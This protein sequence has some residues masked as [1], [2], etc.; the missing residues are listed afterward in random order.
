[1]PEEPY[2]IP[3]GEADVVRE[4]GDVT[5]VALGRMVHLAEPGR[6]RARGRGHR[7]RDHRPAHDLAARRGHDPRERREHRPAR[8]RRRGQPALRVRGRHRS[9]W[10]PSA[11]LRGRSRR[12]RGW[13]RRRTRRCRSARSLEDAYVPDAATRSP[14]AVRATDRQRGGHA[15]MSAADR[16]ARHAQVGPVDDRGPAHRLARRRGRRARQSATRSPRSR[17]RRS[18][19]WSR[20]PAAGV[21]RRRVAAEDEVIPVGGLLGV[22]ADAAAPDEEIDA[23]VAEFQATLRARARRPRTRARPPRDGRGRGRPA[24]PRARAR[25]ASRSCS[26]TASAATSTT[27]CSTPSRWRPSAPSTRSTCPATAARSRRRRRPRG[28]GAARVPGRRQG[29]ERA[30]LVGHSMGGLVAGELRGRATPERV[31][32]LTL[33][34]PARAS[35]P[36]ID[37]EYIDGFIAASRR[38]SSSRCCSCCSPTRTSSPAD[39]RRRAQVQ[40]ARRRRRRAGGPARRAVR[41][42]PP[43]PL[44]RSLA[45]YSGPL[46]VIWGERDAIIPA[47][48]AEAAPDGAEVKS[49]R[50]GHSP[51]MEAA[52]DVNR[53]LEDS[54]PA[55]APADAEGETC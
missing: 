6:R 31:L 13:S 9:R 30:H 23:F 3:F 28:C 27:G 33:I 42:R 55:C 29:I 4:G 10:S 8:G 52:G 25:A 18:T 7:V 15:R 16:E 21:L 51:H 43:G 5:V 39:G 53:L 41:G 20:P 54:W 36:E 46:L 44:A 50:R 40:A 35:A 24:L 2:A 49:C 26:C 34:A 37:S 22:I 45:G 38:S 12:R 1:M 48:H 32:S 14:T 47:A 11:G 19:A 17:P